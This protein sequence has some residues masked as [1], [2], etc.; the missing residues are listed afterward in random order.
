MQKTVGMNQ[1]PLMQ[2]V[3]S[4]KETAQEYEGKT[5]SFSVQLTNQSPA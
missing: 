1:Y 4:M 2:V 3:K 5:S